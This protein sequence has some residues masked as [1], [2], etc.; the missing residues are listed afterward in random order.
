MTASPQILLVDQ[1]NDQLQQLNEYLVGAGYRVRTSSTGEEALQLIESRKFE[2]VLCDI[3]TGARDGLTLSELIQHDYPSITRILIVNQQVLPEALEATAQGAF[4]ILTPPFDRAHLLDTVRAALD[5]AN[6]RRDQ[7]WRAEIVARSPVMENLLD[8]ARRVAVSDV[9]LIITGP[10]GSGKT[11]FAE[12]IHNASR[13]STNPI[14]VLN[15][16]DLPE[17]MLESEL[18]GHRRGAFGGANSDQQGVLSRVQG[19]TLVLKDICDMPP[20]LQVKLHAALQSARTRAIGSENDETVD[21]RIIVCSQRNLEHAMLNGE[22][23]EALYY[24]LNVVNLEIPSLQER[25]EDIPLLARH[26]LAREATKQSRRI[27]NLSPG[28]IHLLGLSAWPG[29]VSQLK[30]VIAQA[31]SKSTSPVIAESL[32]AEAMGNQERVIPSFNEARAEFERRY[33]IKL[34]QIT[35]GNVTHAARIAERNRTDLYKLLGKHDLEPSRFKVRRRHG[36]GGRKSNDVAATPDRTGT[37]G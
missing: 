9:N 32:I 20:A 28:A 13:R 31:V 35:E 5:A 21:V 6:Q 23:D 16:S 7:R 29:N 14:E 11:L 18:F 33:L 26:F 12:A 17:Q 10:N 1:N 34:L 2:L 22:L 3:R 19:G 15:C 25:A 37:Q 4:G 8:Q 24:L 30:K 27:R 36:K